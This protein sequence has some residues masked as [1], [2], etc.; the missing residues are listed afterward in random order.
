LK[1]KLYTSYVYTDKTQAWAAIKNWKDII[2]DGHL[3][4]GGLR[5]HKQEPLE[6]FE[7][8]DESIYLEEDIE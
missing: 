3:V 4:F 1:S 8:V 2:E 7:E 5:K 6:T